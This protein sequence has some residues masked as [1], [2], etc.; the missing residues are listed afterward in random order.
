MLR[1]GVVATVAVLVLAGCGT[2]VDGAP[3]WPGAT[4][5]K[6]LHGLRE[7]IRRG[8]CSSCNPEVCYADHEDRAFELVFRHHGGRVG[9]MVLHG[10]EVRIQG[11]RVP[12]GHVVRVRIGRDDFGLHAVETGQVPDRGPERRGGLLQRM[13]GQ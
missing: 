1:G 7:Q 4:L 5:D 2:T 10:K 3:T 9:V 6:V 13:A 11:A 8:F 12:G